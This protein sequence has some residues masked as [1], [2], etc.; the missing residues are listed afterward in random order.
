[1]T[2]NSVTRSSLNTDLLLSMRAQL[3]TLQRQLGTGQRSETYGG[4]GE[5]R[6]SS[7]NA[8]AELS[9]IDGYRTA[10]DRTNTTLSVITA[11]LERLD[12]L[13]LEVKAE[14]LTT[15]LTIEAGDRTAS[16]VAASYRFQ[17]LA[18]LLNTDVNGR[19]LFS[20]LS[21][22]LEPVASVDSIIEG[23]GG[24]AGLRQVMAER[25][26][27]DLGG[28]LADPV[29]SGR[30]D[31]AV[32]GPVVS[33]AESG[34]DVFGFQ[35]DLASGVS[36]TSAGIVAGTPAGPPDQA[37]FEVVGPVAPG[38]TVRLALTLPDG[39]RESVVL[40]AAGPGDGGAG[41]FEV[42]PD[43]LVTAANLQASLAGVVDTL[44]RVELVAASGVRAGSDFFDQDPPLR[45]VPDAVNGLAGATAV[46]AD[47]VNT[48][49]WYRGEDG[50]LDA[51]QTATARI[52]EGQIIN[53][54]ARA[55]EDALR[56]ALR[57]T[58]VFMTM[59][60]D[61]ADP[62]SANRYQALTERSRAN[63]DDP[64]ARNLPR[65]IGVDVGTAGALMKATE[66]RHIQ[67]RAV[68]QGLLDGT[69]GVSQEEVATRLLNL[70]TRLEASYTVTSILSELSLVNFLR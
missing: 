63:L 14:M 15:S 58:A 24:R 3:D 51:R 23:E 44:A 66:D 16:Q 41:R 20:G 59:R 4:L 29:L 46:A 12:E 64:S 18:S 52:D 22:D 65:S 1:M 19:F 35:L 50:P 17:E 70:Q 26:E 8:R 45:V 40:T 56:T 54:G 67:T 11:T 62:G 7:L 13:A 47:A 60:F 27:A 21:S 68:L 61:A 34:G 55:N 6:L 48:V 31:I 53:Y 57:E 33:L 9:R 30:L 36:S 39:T 10:I 2:I 37:A 49:R 69:D 28:T 43:P 32:A 5:G 42:D 25:A 38:E